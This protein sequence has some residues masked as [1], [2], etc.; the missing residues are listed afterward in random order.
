MVPKAWACNPTPQGFSP[1][2]ANTEANQS[3]PHLHQDNP[4]PK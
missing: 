1:L 3:V 4:Q 2:S